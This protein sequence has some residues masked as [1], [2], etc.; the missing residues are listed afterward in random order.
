MWKCWLTIWQITYIYIYIE[1]RGYHFL[2]NISV[3][4]GY[5]VIPDIN[6]LSPVF[7]S[8][9]ERFPLV[10]PE[11]FRW[12]SPGSTAFSQKPICGALHIEALQY[13]RCLGYG[14]CGRNVSWPLWSRMVCT[15]YVLVCVGGFHFRPPN[16]WCM[17]IRNMARNMYQ[18]VNIQVAKIQKGHGT[19][20]YEAPPKCL[21]P[22]SW[23]YKLPLFHQ[24]LFLQWCVTFMG[25][26]AM[27][28]NRLRDVMSSP[29]FPTVS[30]L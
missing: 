23:R 10:F 13:H 8:P 22:T 24:F 18:K 29:D 2:W 1:L 21:E 16:W 9:S 12:E 7:L 28:P 3:L 25:I 20:T 4:V 17:V 6:L 15:V 5:P 14:R 30:W 26:V 11:P 19:W 27:E